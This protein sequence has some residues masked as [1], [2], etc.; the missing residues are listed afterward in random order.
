MSKRKTGSKTS[1]KKMYKV[2]VQATVKFDFPETPYGVIRKTRKERK[3]K[4]VQLFNFLA[5]FNFLHI[6]LSLDLI[7][8]LE[9]KGVKAKADHDSLQTIF[10]YNEVMTPT[11]SSCINEFLIFISELQVGAYSGG[12]RTL[13]CMLET[14]VE[15]CDF[16]FD[17]NR[18]SYETLV[19][20]FKSH[21]R[22]P[23]RKEKLRSFM[24]EHNAWASFMERYKVYE[25]AKRIA[26]SFKEL[27]N[28]L[29]SREVFREVPQIV[30]EMKRTYE[31][32]SDYIHPSSSRIEKQMERKTE[33]VPHFSSEDFDAIYELGLKTLDMVMFLY[34]KSI[35]H[36]LNF[37]NTKGFISHMHQAMRIPQKLTGSF[38]ALPYSKKLTGGIKWKVIQKH[39]RGR[40]SVR[41]TKKVKQNK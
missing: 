10:R 39:Q 14:A 13:R 25:Q 5:G 40:K 18:S 22:K 4:I 15:A 41:A 29:N 36:F 34:I 28:R 1:H 16:Q 3:S 8:L 37:N 31:R 20:D 27:V 7:F 35:S 21:V 17:S 19:E 30:D 26:P 12:A 33:L 38:L 32:L 24:M 6:I 23:Q 2:T 11:I 9:K